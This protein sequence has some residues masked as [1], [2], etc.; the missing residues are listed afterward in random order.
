MKH[1][2]VYHSVDR[3]GTSFRDG[4]DTDEPFSVV[5]KKNLRVEEDDV[6]WLISGEKPEHG[7][8][9]DYRLEY[10]FL[11]EGKEA[12]DDDEFTY[13]IHGK[14]GCRFSDGI[15]LSRL[16]WFQDFREAQLNF[17]GG[18]Q[19]MREPILRHLYAVVRAASGNT[20]TDEYR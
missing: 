8:E 13:R 19:T 3:M 7:G 18:M 6:V 15:P 4:D 5:T 10:W 9:T 16:K 14:Q 11:I 1:Y 17:R 20:P 2:L 12:L